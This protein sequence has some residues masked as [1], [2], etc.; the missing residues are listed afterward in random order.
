MP[1]DL[2]NCRTHKLSFP[3]RYHM[4][5]VM[6]V[7]LPAPV[8]IDETNNV[9]LMR[10]GLYNIA[11]ELAQKYPG[12]IVFQSY[13]GI[14]DVLVDGESHN[15]AYETAMELGKLVA[16]TVYHNLGVSVSVG[17]GEP[18]AYLDE[19]CLSRRQAVTALEYR[20]FYGEG[21]VICAA[22]IEIKKSQDID[23]S[24]CA[25]RMEEAVKA[26]DQPGAQTV[27]SDMMEAMR[28]GHVPFDRCVLYSQKLVM[29]LMSLVDGILGRQEVEALEKL[30]DKVNFYTVPNIGRLEQIVSTICN[31]AFEG[32]DLVKTDS[33]AA[34]V[35]KAESYMKEHYGDPGLSL[36][37]VTE[38][39]AIST[40][41]FSA[42]FKAKTGSTFVEYLTRLRMDRAKQILAMTDRRTY[43][44]AE[45]VG[46]SDPHYF[47]V[48]FKRVT[49]MTP[50]E[51]REYSASP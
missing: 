51:Y 24:A 12:I 36:N 22:D 31:R 19:L 7:D 39:L 10:Y 2:E 3:G 37:T 27:I 33:A 43:E 13:D 42:I 18:V 11:Q 4:A 23:Y 41:Y 47:S 16:S 25:R 32:F 6:D 49:G 26:M 21:S 5:A 20:F 48:A 1:S 35:R 44:V 9:E 28:N 17:I 30:W 50:K 40:S 15:R 38:Y 34:Q 8:T 45:D 14:T 46:F 29:T